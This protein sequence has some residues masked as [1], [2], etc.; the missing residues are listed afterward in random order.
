M[1]QEFHNIFSWSYEALHGFDPNVIH[2]AIPMKEGGN[3][4]RK[5]QRPMDPT[6]E[7]TIR[8]E[9]EKLLNDHI[10][11]PVKYSERILNLVPVQKKLCKI[12]L[13]ANFHPLNRA[14]VKD[15]FPL[16]NMEMML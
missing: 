15:K 1:F 12:R 5:K 4:V 9:E 16:P 13:C 3:L 6:L 2:H 7:A 10:I 8:K 11:F 14:S